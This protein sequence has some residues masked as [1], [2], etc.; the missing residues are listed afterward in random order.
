LMMPQRQRSRAEDRA[1]RIKAERE[2]NN[3]PPPPF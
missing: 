3:S 1:A 2:H